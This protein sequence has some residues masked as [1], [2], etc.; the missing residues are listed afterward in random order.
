MEELDT[1]LRVPLAHAVQHKSIKVEWIKGHRKEA[2]AFNAVDKQDIRYNN[3]TDGLA[4]QAAKLAPQDIVYTSPASI[5]IAGG[6]A[7]TPAVDPKAAET[8]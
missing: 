1:D 6:E 7:P 4:K 8:A 5:D 2:E 3:I